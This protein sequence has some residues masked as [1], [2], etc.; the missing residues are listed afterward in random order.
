MQKINPAIPVDSRKAVTT[1]ITVTDAT[2]LFNNTGDKDGLNFF[3][4]DLLVTNGH[5]TNGTWVTIVN[6]SNA[7]EVLWKGYASEKGGGFAQT[8]KT[9]ILC[10]SKSRIQIICSAAAEV[11]VSASGLLV[12][13]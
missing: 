9:A 11:V 3:I 7:N 6:A 4:T 13:Q 8:L 5:A 1:N 10:G 12:E 2:D